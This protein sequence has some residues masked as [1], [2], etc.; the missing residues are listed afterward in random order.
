M[1]FRGLLGRLPYESRIRIDTRRRMNRLGS[2]SDA[3]SV[4]LSQPSTRK[5]A[6]GPRH[7][8]IK[9]GAGVATY[10]AKSTQLAHI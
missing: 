10:A 5:R 4:H 7:T 3:Y 2:P 8:I 1:E 9:A 6:S